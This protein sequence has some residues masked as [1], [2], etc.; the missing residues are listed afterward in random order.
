VHKHSE[1]WWEK[2]KT[3]LILSPFFHV[4]YFKL[5]EEEESTRYFIFP[6]FKQKIAFCVSV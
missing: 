4:N 2:K 5:V 1:N 6:N 3:A